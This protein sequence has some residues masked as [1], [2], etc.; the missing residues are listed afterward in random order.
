MIIIKTELNIKLL[1]NKI[2]KINVLMTQIVK[3]YYLLPKD[4][5]MG[6]V[7]FHLLK[8]LNILN[9]EHLVTLMKK[10]EIFYIILIILLHIFIITLHYYFYI[11]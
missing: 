6:N 4:L 5:G 9:V 8:E 3:L 10:Y 1:V 2:V 7:G 11:C